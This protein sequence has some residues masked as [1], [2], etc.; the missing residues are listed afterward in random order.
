MHP[1]DPIPDAQKTDINPPLEMP[2]QQLHSRIHRWNQQTHE[3]KFQTIK[4]KPP[5]PAE[6]TTSPQNTQKQNLVI[7]Q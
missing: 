7:L 2:S 4:I 5:V 6:T 1:K 3:K